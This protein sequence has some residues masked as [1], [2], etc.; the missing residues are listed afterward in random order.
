MRYE[1]VLWC[2]ILYVFET[3]FMSLGVCRRMF[4]GTGGVFY[5]V[6]GVLFCVGCILISS[7]FLANLVIYIFGCQ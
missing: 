3:C 4:Y 5:E 7:D 2:G 1:R 6:G